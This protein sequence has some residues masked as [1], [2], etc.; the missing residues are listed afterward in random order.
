MKQFKFKINGNLYN[1]EIHSMEDSVAS[2]EVNG[3]SYKVE[4]QKEKNAPKTPRIVNRP[5]A[6]QKSNKPLTTSKLSQVK[7]PL[8][9]TVL[10][11]LVKEGD[12]VKSEQNLILMEAMKMENKILSEGSGVV[13]KIHV[14]TGE[15]VLQDQLLLEIE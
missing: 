4:L 7:A 5:L 11:I 15:N 2:I 10:E 13:K 1:V 14:T 9:G 12:T 3:T 6:P 8:P